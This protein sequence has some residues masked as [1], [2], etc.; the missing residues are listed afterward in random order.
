MSLPKHSRTEKGAFRRERADALVKNLKKVYPELEG[1]NGNK[2][3]GTL[4]DELGVN[5]LSQVLKK[6][7]EE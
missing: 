5:S 3:L 7:R 1:I 4:R 2:K 6:L